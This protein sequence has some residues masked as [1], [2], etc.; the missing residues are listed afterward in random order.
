MRRIAQL[1]VL[2]GV[3][4]TAQQPVSSVAFSRSTHAIRG[5][6][7]SGDVTLQVSRQQLDVRYP[8]GRKERG[9]IIV[10]YDPPSGHYFWRYERVEPRFPDS[11]FLHAF[12]A[13]K[14]VVYATAP[15]LYEF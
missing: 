1:F 8:G 11:S 2:F 15:G 3:P 5:F 10:I 4:L 7:D 13:A 14:E 9:D 6:S 12:E